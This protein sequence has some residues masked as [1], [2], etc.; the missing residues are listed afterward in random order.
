M[1]SLQASSLTRLAKRAPTCD[2]GVGTAC[3]VAD[4]NNCYAGIVSRLFSITYESTFD[5]D[6]A[7]QAVSDLT[8]DEDGRQ[9]CSGVI[10][11]SV[12]DC[13]VR[14]YPRLLLP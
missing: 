7:P 10:S 8:E 4:A 14:A 9:Q 11:D 5:C 2:E 13:S 6:C 3:T 1:E 12:N